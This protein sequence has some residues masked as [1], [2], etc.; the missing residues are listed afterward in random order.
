MGCIENFY[1]VKPGEIDEWVESVYGD[2][3]RRIE[4]KAVMD[5]IMVKKKNNKAVED[6]RWFLAEAEGDWI[7]EEAFAQYLAEEEEEL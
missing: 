5:H 6:L 1:L 3:G 7:D 2:I 4:L